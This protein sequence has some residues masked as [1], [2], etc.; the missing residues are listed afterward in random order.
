MVTFVPVLNFFKVYGMKNEVSE[1]GLI[2]VI[3]SEKKFADRPNG[4]LAPDKNA[5]HRKEVSERC[6]EVKLQLERCRR[7]L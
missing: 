6:R 7:L 5:E 1:P 4:P 3:T 2:S